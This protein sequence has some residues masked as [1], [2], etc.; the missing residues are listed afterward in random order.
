[1]VT[2]LYNPAKTKPKALRSAIS[3]LGYKAN[4]ASPNQT[5]KAESNQPSKI[6]VP[7]NAPKFFVDAVERARAL[8][9]PVIID[10]W[11]SW[12]GACLQLKRITLEHPAVA[13][14]LLDVEVIFVDLDI[15][16]TL[17]EAYSVASIPDVIFID[18][19]GAIVDRLHNFEPPEAFIARVQKVLNQP[20]RSKIGDQ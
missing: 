1:M 3:D 13:K 7:T 10:F 19:S 20:A 14:A 18:V 9:K 11:A 8:H 15:N 6:T 5:G 2:V 12:C 16:P 4:L 17:G